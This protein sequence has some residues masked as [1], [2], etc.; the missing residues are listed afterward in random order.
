MSTL[1]QIKN[2]S[3]TYN[4][5]AILINANVTISEH[6]KIGVVGRNGAGKSTLFK[7]IIGQELP[8]SG[9]IDIHDI[10]RL[11]YLEQHDATDEWQTVLEYLINTSGKEH[12][13]C[14]KIAGK[15]ELKNELLDAPLHSLSGGYQMRAKL[16]ALLLKDPN[17]F[18]LDEPTNYL[19]VHTQLLLE[20]F[21][22][23]YTGT[24]LVISHDRE[25]LRRTCSET[26]EIDRGEIFL[27]PGPVDEYF[28]YKNEQ[29]EMKERYNKKIEREQKHLQNFVDRFRYKA[30]KAAQ[31]QSKLK[32]IGRLKKMD[33]KEN[34][35]TVHIA[36]PN[37]EA[38]KGLACVCKNLTIGYPEKTVA[39]N[40]HLNIERGEHVAIVGDNGQ[41]KTTFFKTLANAIPALAGS[42]RWGHNISIAYYAQH[43]PSQLPGDEEVWQY[44]R[45]NAPLNINDEDVLRMAGNFLFTKEALKKS[46]EILSGG[47][48]AR[49]CLAS[50][51]L[52]ESNV[53][54]LDE[55]TNHLDFET[56]EAL[57]LALADFAGTILFISHNRTFVN[58]VATSVI[59]VNSGNVRR[60]ADSY[61]NYVAHL[62]QLIQQEAAS[63][64]QKKSKRETSPVATPEPKQQNH[65]EQKQRKKDLRKIEE[66]ITELER[67][68]DHLLKKQSKDPQKFGHDDYKNLGEVVKQLE[69]KE[70][71]WAELQL[72]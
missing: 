63:S 36:I 28:E 30:S 68:R 5:Q 22:Q 26:M 6:Q 23:S 24:F 27:Y 35:A 19:D 4:E 41:G 64:P 33:I 20:K 14:A 31:A 9:T 21:L 43:I 53:L 72:N 69:E 55:P 49:L 39:E 16:A 17:L 51:L 37:V 66:E 18:L 10:T 56:V 38:K 67:T 46:I 12:W 57:G 45:T 58:S 15:F 65:D 13:Q 70:K 52:S 50:L 54:L 32:A 25:F 60:Y 62:E 59:E 3:K 48:R 47:E 34:A 61:E 71:K 11:G 8:D 7:M 44:I 1:L 2:I 42:F 29:V 40:I